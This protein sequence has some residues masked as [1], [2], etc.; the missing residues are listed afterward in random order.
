MPFL[1]HQ[2]ALF[3]EYQRRHDSSAKE[4]QRPPR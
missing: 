4:S 1:M 2:W 3:G